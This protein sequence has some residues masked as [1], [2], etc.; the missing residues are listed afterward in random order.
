M[1]LRTAVAT[2][3]VAA[4]LLAT[5]TTARHS[6]AEWAAGRRIYQIMTDRFAV[7][8]A[9]SG[10][11][12]PNVNDYCG[13]TFDGAAAHL[14]YI[15]GMGFNAIWISPV[16]VNWKESYHGYAATDFFK[17]NP[18]FGTPEQLKSFVQAAHA[19]GV[20]IMVDIVLNHVA[21][22]GTDFSQISPFNE[23]QYYHKDCPVTSYV[24]ETE[25]IQHCRLLNLPDLNQDNAYTKQQL[26]KY[27]QWLMTEFEFDGIRADTVMYIKNS[28]WAEAQA[29]AN[30]YIAGEVYSDFSCNLNYARNGIDATLN[31]PL[32]FTV[33]KVYQ[34][35]QSM[36]TLG[37]AY[38]QQQQYPHPT[39][40]ANFIDNQ[41]QD[42]WLSGNGYVPLYQ[43]ALAHMY[44][45][46]G[47]PIVY[48]GTEQE[49]K[50]HVS[51]NENRRPLWPTGFNRN[52]TM[53]AFLAGLSAAHQH[54]QVWTHTYVE[55]WRD[56]SIY[57]Y[58]RGPLLVCTCN[59][60]FKGQTRTVPDLPFAGTTLCNWF[61]H[62]D[63]MQ[64]AS[65]MTLTVPPGAHPRVWFASHGA[66]DKAAATAA[67]E[68]AMARAR[69]E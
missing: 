25:E 66:A 3:L 16:P 31:Y 19:K 48:Y 39:W 21:P 8:A 61:N 1:S 27:V 38:R 41:D 52:T 24:C 20:W 35:G 22:V 30:A 11:A 65:T 47:I 40:E 33:R 5:A 69:G 58:M 4:V 42:R 12:C 67:Y 54:F 46:D 7:S 17:I 44:F 68:A 43:S 37:D 34:S 15:T 14:D 13:G 29:T 64:G 2:T 59:E 63:C 10:P 55:R 32:F 26:L 45:S 6:A 23:S 60:G 51:T 28:F 50:G 53:Y 18:H 57:C 36:R 49:M 62:S 56:D 9:N